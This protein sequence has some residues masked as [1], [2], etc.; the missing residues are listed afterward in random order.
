MKPMPA[1]ASTTSHC[2][3]L[4]LS[5][6]TSP[7]HRWNPIAASTHPS[8]TGRLAPPRSSIR[9]PICEAIT[10]PMKNQSRKTPA[11]EEESP[12]AICAYSLEKK[13]TG[14]KTSIEIPSTRFCTENARMRKMST[15][16]SGEAVR[17]STNAKTTS[18][19]T[20]AAMQSPI[21]GLDQPQTCDCW[22]PKT[23]S[24]T[25]P[26]IRARPR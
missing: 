10:K 2:C 3:S 12:S 1:P 16:I 17:F 5:E 15:L 11:S 25:P 8:T 7:A 9:P 21:A 4:K 14:T 23:L 20:P 18:S 22:N 6:V 13:N 26:A 19:A 24:A